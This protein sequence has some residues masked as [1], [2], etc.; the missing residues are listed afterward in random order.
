[1]L[2]SIL[3]VVIIFYIPLLL[4]CS[5]V[6]KN[7]FNSTGKQIVLRLEPS[8]NNPR[9][10]E[11]DFITLKDGRLL[12][13]Y[14]HFTA[15]AGDH[16][17]AFLASR[18]SKDGGK[19]WSQRDEVVIEN[20]GGFN[21]M[22][23]SLLRLQDGRIALFY[24]RKNSLTD[25]IPLMRISTDEAKTWSD[26]VECIAETAYYV[27]NND[28]AIQL[29]N[30]R[31]ILP[32]ALHQEP[33]QKWSNQGRIMCYY[34]DDIG[35]SW[36]R[37]EQAPNPEGVIV[38]E[39]GVVELEDGSVY[40][41]CR[42]DA[43]T[44]Y[45][46]TSNDDGMSWSP[47]KSS[48][49]K[50]PLSP[51]SIERIP[52]TGDLLMLWNNNYKPL[53]DGDRRTPFNMAISRDDGKS[54]EKTKQ[55]END[56]NGWYC[57]TAIHFEDDYVVLG[58]CAGDR[59]ENNGL[60]AEQITLL[61][62]DWIY[63]DPLPNPF[64]KSDK[65]GKVELACDVDDTKIYYTMDGSLPTD[66]SIL[67]ESPIT[68]TKTGTINYKAFKTGE[69][70]SELVYATVGT[71]VLQS[72]QTVKD[73]QPGIHYN[74]YEGDFLKVSDFADT[75]PK[76]Q[77][78]AS[79]FSLEKR[80]AEEYFALS[81]ECFIKVRQDGVYTFYLNSNDGSILYLN[82]DIFIDSDG[83]HGEYEKFASTA[84]RNGYHKLKLLYFQQG[85]GKALNVSWKGPDFEKHEIP[86]DALF[87]DI[88]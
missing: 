35:K 80:K 64:V 52:A 39:P 75:K 81:F 37:G 14:S 15:G 77:G 62:H 13:I 11:G 67:Y 61:S 45:I 65:N 4:F 32:V 54:W 42:A 70:P 84:L 51:A 30:G 59:K 73:A 74:Y 28:R 76:R 69:I 49:I 7:S 9:N 46:C 19:T 88:R 47:L 26:P 10:S 24:G 22:S 40:M 63:R 78:V 50:S 68:V 36:N 71:D 2:R 3:K 86:P 85:G 31:I 66:N 48:N 72:A 79:S 34:S 38:Q 33:E 23:V 6:Q 5:S 27:L 57:Y 20:E 21:I 83:T 60:A 25:C 18:L 58:H 44:Q 43:G 41:F 55:V 1:M 87:I 8:E 12:F 82:D 53:S 16:A 29:K 17:Q 56:P